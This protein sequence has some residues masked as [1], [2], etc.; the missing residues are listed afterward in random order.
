MPALSV[1]AETQSV[2]LCSK[3]DPPNMLKPIS[4]Q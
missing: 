2:D 4:L 1:V 3:L